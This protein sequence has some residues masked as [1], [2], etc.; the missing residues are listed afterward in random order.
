MRVSTIGPEHLGQMCGSIIKR[1]E[2][3]KSASK[4]MMFTFVQAEISRAT[5]SNPEL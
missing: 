4:D 3:D 5:T 2:S 1:L